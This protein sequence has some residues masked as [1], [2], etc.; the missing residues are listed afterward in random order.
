MSEESRP[1][2]VSRDGQI[3]TL[4]LNRPRVRNAV[5]HQ[6]LESM[7]RTLDDLARERPWVILLRASTPGFCAGI[8][9]KETLDADP[10]FVRDRVSTMHRVLRKLRSIP[11]P[12]VAAIDGPA[13]G[14][15]VELAISADLRF[16]SA[17]SRF[18]YREVAV[19]VPSPAHHL[20]RV[21]GLTRAQ[22]LLLTARWMEADEAER[23]GLVTRLVPDAEAAAADAARQIAE[24]APRAVQDTKE[25]IWISVRQG[26]DAAA[27]HHIDVVATAALTEDRREA[28]TA[29]R[30]KRPPRYAGR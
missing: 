18:S 19:A 6:L 15:G 27:L 25:N 11:V 10:A 28:L 4:T 14:L 2:L 21:I 24:L 12:I 8:D 16:A 17:A 22:D 30:E 7:E 1:L 20:V 13:V 5:S 26:V 23:V 9:L 3:V 29:F